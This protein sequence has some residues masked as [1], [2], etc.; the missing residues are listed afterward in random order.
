MHVSFSIDTC[1]NAAQSRWV[2]SRAAG[3]LDRR[4]EIG[5][6]LA[7]APLLNFL[8]GLF[9][10]VSRAARPVANGGLGCTNARETQGEERVLLVDSL[11]F[12]VRG[13]GLG[14]RLHPESI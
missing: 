14:P 13:E 2:G 6:D 3:T 9:A 11:R 7:A 5:G 4:R 10:G 1:A 12:E 8:P